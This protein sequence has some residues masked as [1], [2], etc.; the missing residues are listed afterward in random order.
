MTHAAHLSHASVGASLPL[1]NLPLGPPLL[2][3]RAQFA[4]GLGRKPAA[5]AL[6]AADVPVLLALAEEVDPVL[7]RLVDLPLGLLE[8]PGAHLG[9]LGGG[10][11]RVHL[12]VVEGQEHFL[13]AAH[14]GSAVVGEA[15]RH[16]GARRVDA[17][18]VLVRAAR[19]VGPPVGRDVVDAAV[20]G[21]VDG[22]VLVLA[23][24]AGELLGG[25]VDGFLL[26]R[27]R[28]LEEDRK[29]PVKCDDGG[30]WTGWGRPKTKGHVRIC[31]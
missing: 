17:G 7:E 20:D 16:V 28:E 1:R 26:K 19:A 31:S 18:K 5:L 3:G 15:A 13:D 9:E 12:R 25:Q 11:V 30:N 14:V 21:Q 22:L 23:V 10:E 29:E 2:R 8:L 6:D 27:R 4:P 24:E